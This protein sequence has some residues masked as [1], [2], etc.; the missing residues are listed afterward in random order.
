MEPFLERK[1]FRVIEEIAGIYL[2]PIELRFAIFSFLELKSLFDASLV[3][4]DFHD[5]A[6]GMDM[7]ILLKEE[8][9]LRRKFTVDQ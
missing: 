7:T 2:L 4:K 9:I 6:T 5:Y 8:T 1:P 3:C